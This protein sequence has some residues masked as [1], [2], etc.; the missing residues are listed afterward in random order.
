MLIVPLWSGAPAT[1]QEVNKVQDDVRSAQTSQIYSRTF[2]ADVKLVIY[3]QINKSKMHTNAL[4]N[5][6]FTLGPE[7]FEKPAVA[8]LSAVDRSATDAF[9]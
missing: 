4:Q 1:V 8:L 5:G 9:S 3:G 7:G 2:E 6:N